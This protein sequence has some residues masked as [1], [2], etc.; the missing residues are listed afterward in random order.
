MVNVTVN[1]LSVSVP[2]GSTILE[3]TRVA[4]FPVPTLCFLK[5]INEIGACRVCV[6]ELEG[7]DRFDYRLQQPVHGRHGDPDKLPEGSGSPE[8]QY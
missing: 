1:G 8:N 4:G 6:V 2:E 5:G 7:A 3:A